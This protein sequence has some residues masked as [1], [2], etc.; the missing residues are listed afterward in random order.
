MLNSISWLQYGLALAVLVAGYYSVI[1]TIYYRTEITTILN[2]K[3]A[4][5]QGPES[6]S[7]YENVLGG[8]KNDIHE[9]SLSSEELLFTSE[10]PNHLNEENY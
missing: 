9:S 10:S 1:L 7:Q 4:G 3:K 8:I 6:Q 5:E 2:L